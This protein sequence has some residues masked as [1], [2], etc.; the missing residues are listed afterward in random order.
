MPRV[1]P[2]ALPLVC[3]FLAALNAGCVEIGAAAGE[4]AGNV[5]KAPPRDRLELLCDSVAPAEAIASRFESGWVPARVTYEG[6]VR[7]REAIAVAV[8]RRRWSELA[9]DAWTL[10][11]RAVDGHSE[12]RELDRDT[13]EERLA[14]LGGECEQ[15]APCAFL[16]L[17][18]GRHTVRLLA[19]STGEKA[20]PSQLEGE[21]TFDA[22]AGGVYAMIACR[23]T[24][25]AAPIFWVRDETSGACV[26]SVCPR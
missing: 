5:F 12:V 16:A 26:S 1:S 22:T 13:G 8:V 18:P 6:P 14:E 2:I 20:S 11:A 7:E 19:V 3:S 10:F 4:A 25:Q 24:A 9:G 17:L 15:D 21:T 23:P